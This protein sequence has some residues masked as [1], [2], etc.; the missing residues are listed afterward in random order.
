MGRE[1]RRSAEN[2]Q[3]EFV[4]MNRPVRVNERMPREPYGRQSGQA[5]RRQTGQ[6][7]QAG[8]A[9]GRQSGQVRQM[10]G[11]QSSRTPR[12]DMPRSVQPLPRRNPHLYEEQGRG[13]RAARRTGV[14]RR[15]KLRLRALKRL[16][17]GAV[18]ITAVL[19]FFIFFFMDTGKTGSGKGQNVDMGGPATG[20]G[21]FADAF[22]AQ[23]ERPAWTEDFLSISEW[24]RPGEKLPEVKNIYVHYTAN[25]GTSAAQNRSYFE[26]LKDSHKTAASAHFIIGYEGEIINCVP[27]DEVAYAV[28]GKN[29]E[30][31]S[32][33][34]CYLA[35]DGSFTQE[36]YDSLIKLLRWLIDTYHLDS[37]DILRHYDSNGKKCPIYYV[38]NEDAWEQLKRDVDNR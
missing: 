6:T 11:R 15:K 3:L 1:N 10:P 16:L 2:I 25:K 32:I 22:R 29:Y 37:G 8:G 12:V 21:M 36:T 13:Q 7:R 38:E 20:A 28:S 9:Y 19:L 14:R 26:G 33:E 4:N 30:S 35:D 18:G 34:C 23:A 27:V 24:A 17:G 5:V 31:I